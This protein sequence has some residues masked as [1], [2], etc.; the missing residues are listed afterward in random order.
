MTIKAI[1]VIK[2]IT[3]I[4]VYFPR[5][6]GTLTPAAV[7][8]R[9]FLRTSRGGNPELFCR[10]TLLQMQVPNFPHLSYDLNTEI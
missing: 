3:A 9:G 4:R 8:R 5:F 7:K 10:G 1:T 6:Y 2:A